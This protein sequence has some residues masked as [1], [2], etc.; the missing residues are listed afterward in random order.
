MRH[1]RALAALTIGL[2]LSAPAFAQMTGG[3]GGMG[4]YGRGGMGTMS[5][6]P[7]TD[8]YGMALRDIRR[9]KYAEAIPYLEHA[10]QQRP[11]DADIMNL[12]GSTNRLVGNYPL[13]EAWYRKALAENPDHTRAHENLG[14]LYLVLR[15]LP[16]AQAQL[17]E[18]V[19]L[20]PD[21]CDDRAA[22]TRSIATYQASA[23]ATA[24]TPQAA[25]TKP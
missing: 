13:S 12:L 22:L 20:C 14:E 1:T 9:Q 21:S 10:L 4:G 6:T 11:H 5:L 2:S 17:A 16:S 19:R 3:M 24:P 23:A 25:V 15:D 8:F 18:L 7:Q